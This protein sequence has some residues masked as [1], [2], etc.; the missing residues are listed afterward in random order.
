M[1][2]TKQIIISKDLHRN[3]KKYCADNDQAMRDFADAVI[4]N[5]IIEQVTIEDLKQ[6]Q[7]R[8]SYA[9]TQQG[10]PM[11]RY[12]VKQPDNIREAEAIVKPEEVVPSLDELKEKESEEL[13][14]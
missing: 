4:E 5:A 14:W 12:G 2:E 8:D 6:K 10:G 7:Y 1:S 13:G 3:L 9:S 11:V